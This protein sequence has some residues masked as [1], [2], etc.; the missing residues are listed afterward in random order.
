LPLNWT[1]ETPAA[2]QPYS[3][4]H[5]TG[6]VDSLSAYK[7]AAAIEALIDQGH[8]VIADLAGIAFVSSAGWGAFIGQQRLA[9]NDDR[10]LVLAAMQR[11]VREVY[12]TLGLQS[13]LAE[14]PSIDEAIRALE[15]A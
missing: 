11:Q 2:P 13:V 7:L 10:P 4:I 14:Y 15:T 12:A 5:L 6:A 1:I 3:V 8:T 9:T